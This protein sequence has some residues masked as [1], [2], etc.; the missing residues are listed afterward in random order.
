MD[1]AVRG[2]DPPAEELSGGLLN[3]LREKLEGDLA[4]FAQLLPRIAHT[5]LSEADLSFLRPPDAPPPRTNVRDG[6]PAGGD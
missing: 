2:V 3:H 5:Q 1:S 4:L 6:A